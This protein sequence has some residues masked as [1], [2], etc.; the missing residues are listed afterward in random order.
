MGVTA[1]SALISLYPTDSL[2]GF[3]CGARW[4]EGVGGG[5]RGGRSTATLATATVQ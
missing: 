1:T 3:M 2:S 4:R 5:E